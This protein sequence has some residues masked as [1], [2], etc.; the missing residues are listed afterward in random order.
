MN[1]RIGNCDQ[2]PSVNVPIAKSL[3]S[4]GK[5]C[6]PC[7]RKRLEATKG[8]VIFTLKK[9]AGGLT[10]AHKKQDASVIKKLVKELDTVFS[11]FI[12][13]RDADESGMVSC[14][15]C[16]T[17]R[18]WKEMHCGHLYSRASFAIRW[19]VNNAHAQ[20]PEC[21]LVGNGRFDQHLEYARKLHGDGPI[22]ILASIKNNVTN[23]NDPVS[24]H[25]KKVFS[26][27]VPINC[28][29][30]FGFNTRAL[31]VVLFFSRSGWPSIP[32]RSFIAFSRSGSPTISG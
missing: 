19:H 10:T 25:T 3:P 22:V 2:C 11:I 29:T 23:L 13:T 9:R 26:K 15:T 4:S 17:R 1:K 24:G 31:P 16:P 5:W 7:N 20:C 12:R 6:V 8:P 30:H 14:C 21:N 32:L 27:V 18:H 28:N